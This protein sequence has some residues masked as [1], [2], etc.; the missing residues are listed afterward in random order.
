MSSTGN[1]NSEDMMEV[2][3]DASAN[4][5]SVIDPQPNE[6]DELKQRFSILP[7]EQISAE[8]LFNLV[9]ALIR[10]DD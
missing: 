2:G 6:W 5:D 1:N 10:T 4:P 7:L 3:T 8:L 9:F